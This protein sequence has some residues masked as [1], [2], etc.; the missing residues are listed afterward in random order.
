MNLCGI[1]EIV[2]H[3]FGAD[4]SR[5]VEKAS[6]TQ[7]AK[8]LKELAEK[9]GELGIRIAVE[10]LNFQLCSRVSDLLEIIEG[11]GDHVGICLD[12]GHAHIAGLDPVRELRTAHSAGKLLSLHINDVKG[13]GKD[14]FIP[15]T[16]AKF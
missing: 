15:G 7:S 12:V 5:A 16:L 1:E 10:N 14:H 11:L 9:A 13:T 6:R 3:P 4:P 8:S 2:I